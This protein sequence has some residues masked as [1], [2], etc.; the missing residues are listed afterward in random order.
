MHAGINGFTQVMRRNVGCHTDSDTGTAVNEQMRQTGGEYCRFFFRIVVI[1]NKVN[2]VLADIGEH[3]TGQLLQLH[4]GVTHGSCGVTVETA[5]V[6]LT[7]NQRITKREGLSHTN[8]RI[9]GSRI[10]VR[11]ILTDHIPDH[12]G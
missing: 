2:R 8:D 11:V 3:F 6:T 9:V 12:T 5:E 10:S 1:G 7:I 4:F